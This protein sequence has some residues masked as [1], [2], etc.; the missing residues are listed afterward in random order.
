MKKTYLKPAVALDNMELE[1]MIAASDNLLI[2]VDNSM[3]GDPAEADARRAFTILS[4]W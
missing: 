2:D 3:I 4:L 1:Q